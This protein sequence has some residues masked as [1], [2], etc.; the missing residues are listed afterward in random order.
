M[1]C[2][3]LVLTPAGLSTDGDWTT[4]SWQLRGDD[5][6]DFTL[7]HAVPAAQQHWLADTDRGDHA[8]PPVLLWAM[9]HRADI[10]V[11]GKVSPTLLDGLDT[12]QQ[13]WHRWKPRRYGLIAIRVEEES[14]ALAVGTD[15]PAL[16]AFSGGVDAS[17]SLFRHLRGQAGR[18]NRKPGAALLVHGMD[19]PLDRADFYERACERAAQMLVDTDAALLRM[20]TNSRRLPQLWEDSFGLQLAG[21]YLSLQQ[22]FAHA[23]HGSGEPYDT[24]LMPWG[25]TPLTDQLCSTSIMGIEHDGCAFDRTDKVHW[26]GTQTAIAPYLRVCWAGEKL[27]QNCGECEKCVRTMLNFWAVALPVPS[28]FPTSLTPERVRSIQPKNEVQM[29]ELK[30]LYRHAAENQSQ[31][32]PVMR[33]LKGVIR[34]ASIRET[35]NRV[36]ARLFRA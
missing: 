2:K 1:T 5:L 18:N 6:D 27:D 7:T 12:L 13:I 28:A 34:R 35:L 22:H 16:F 3:T 19:I 9:Q 8:L 24:L 10:V 11:E 32:D 30:S 33:A 25:T 21:C 4:L 29:R 26:L 20:R 36:S 15:R 31:Q 23:L 14:E 17:F